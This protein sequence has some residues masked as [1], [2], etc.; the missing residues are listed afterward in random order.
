MYTHSKLIFYIGGAAILIGI[1]MSA[2]GIAN[3]STTPATVPVPLPQQVPIPPAQ[4]IGQ[5]VMGGTAEGAGDFEI[6]KINADG[7]GLVNLTN[8]PARDMLPAWSPDKS[9][10]AFTSDR[11]GKTQIY[12]MNADG[13]GDPTDQ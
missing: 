13:S 5:I 3:P 1:V 11:D 7:T 9:R 10:I 8:N 6:Y 2:C 12:L 4:S